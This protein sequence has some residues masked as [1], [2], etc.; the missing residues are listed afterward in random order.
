VAEKENADRIAFVVINVPQ[1]LTGLQ[2]LA[3][4][5]LEKAGLEYDIIPIDPGTADMTAQM[6]EVVDSGAGVVQITGNDGFCIAALN[7]LET[8]G[9]EGAVTAVGQCFTD[10]T[11]EAVAGDVLEGISVTS[12]QALGAEDDP[13]FQLYTS[14]I[15]TFGDDVEDV[16]N[17][18][19]MGGYVS[20]AS[21]LTSLEGLEGD[22]TP[23]T[24][25]EAIKSM[26]KSDLPGGGGMTFQCGGSALALLPAVCTNEALR[27]ELDADGRPTTYEVVDASDI[28]P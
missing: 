10:A 21:L 22:V 4:T 7:A 3:P 19:A 8:V 14:V 5:V 13:T 15:S 25:V 28:L 27:T 17:A 24:V 2:G 11:R 23:E 9:Y 6:Q 12:T 16:N 20:M 26:E 18:T 1:A